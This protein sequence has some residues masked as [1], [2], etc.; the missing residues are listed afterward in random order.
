MN[1]NNDAPYPPPGTAR[2][3]VDELAERVAE[4]GKCVDMLHRWWI[5]EDDAAPVVNPG[6][7]SQPTP[8]QRERIVELASQRLRERITAEVESAAAAMHQ[9]DDDAVRGHLERIADLCAGVGDE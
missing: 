5:G 7:G 8:E 3:R 6:R 9:R 1:S 2:D 4:L